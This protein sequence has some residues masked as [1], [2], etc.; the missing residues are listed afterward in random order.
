MKAVEFVTELKGEAVLTIPSD[1]AAQLPKAGNARIIVL[2][3]APMVD[4]NW[5]AAAYEQF[6]CDDPLAGLHLRFDAFRE[7]WNPHMKL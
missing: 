1:I 5:S 6:L 3:E 7:S 4:D 2:T